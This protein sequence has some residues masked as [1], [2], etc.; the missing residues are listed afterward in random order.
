MWCEAV[1]VIV[2]VIF[3]FE[4]EDHCVA[5]STTALSSPVMFRSPAA[6]KAAPANGAKRR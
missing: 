3:R 4:I 6:A 2:V 1:V 5:A